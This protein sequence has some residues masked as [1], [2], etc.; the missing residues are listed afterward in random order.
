MAGNLFLKIE[1]V[2]GECVEKNHKDW[3]DVSSY[4]EGLHHSNSSGFGGGG[5]VGSVSYSDFVVNCQ[6]EKAIPTLM[7]GCAGN[8][9]YPTAKLHATKMDGTKSWNYLEITMSKVLVTSINFSG[10]I[11]EIPHVQV[12]LAFEKIQTDYFLQGPGGTQGANTTAVWDQ[13][14]NS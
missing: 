1:G 2:A 8:K 5:G 11:N 9:E 6:L 13:K 3:I 4:S 14:A 7:A 12:S 10:S